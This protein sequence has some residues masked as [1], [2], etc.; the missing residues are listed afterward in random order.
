VANVTIEIDIDGQGNV[1][2]KPNPAFAGNGD[3]VTWHIN[4]NAKGGGLITLTLP[5][6]PKSPF[7]NEADSVTILEKP[8]F[9]NNMGQADPISWPP[10]TTSYGYSVGF[11]GSPLI[12]LFRGTLRKADDVAETLL[13]TRSRVHLQ[14]CAA[15]R[16]WRN[17]TGAAQNRTAS[18]YPAQGEFPAGSVV[19]VFVAP[20]AHTTAPGPGMNPTTVGASGDSIAKNVPNGSALFV[21]YD[22][23]TATATRVDADISNEP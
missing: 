3:T 7:G 22:Q 5:G 18:V 6:G 13:L 16:V 10:G 9:C 23:G 11:S 20:D 17:Q 4:S 1:T 2:V 12:S 19:T 21:H 8:A 14:H 15:Y